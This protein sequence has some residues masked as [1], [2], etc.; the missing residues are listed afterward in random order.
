M[1][2][3]HELWCVVAAAL[4]LAAAEDGDCGRSSSRGCPATRTNATFEPLVKV[5]LA[6]GNGTLTVEAGARRALRFLDGATG[7]SEGQ[8]SFVGRL[9][10]ARYATRA[11]TY[12]PRRDY[13][14]VPVRYEAADR[15]DLLVDDL[16]RDFGGL[17]EGVG[18]PP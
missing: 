1:R 10:D 14:S 5:T 13:Y 16:G 15:V 9:T 17:P 11:L 18:A 6:A 12:E 3:G 2:F 4:A 8:F 7:V